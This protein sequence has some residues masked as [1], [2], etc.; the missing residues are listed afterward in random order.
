[1]KIIFL[2]FTLF[3]LNSCGVKGDLYLE[4]KQQISEKK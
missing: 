4:E 3:L 1:M 2:I